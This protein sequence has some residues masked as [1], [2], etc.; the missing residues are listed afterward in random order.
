MV[1]GGGLWCST[2]IPAPKVQ[3]RFHARTVGKRPA[4]GVTD[5]HPRA[6]A[7]S[8]DGSVL[9]CDIQQLCSRCDGSSA[10]CTECEKRQEREEARKVLEHRRWLA[11]PE[12]QAHQRAE[13][14]RER[15]DSFI[16]SLPMILP[17]AFII[18]IFRGWHSLYRLIGS[19]VSA[20][21]ES[22]FLTKF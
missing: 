1:Q 4:A 5:T 10:I 3:V 15:M 21:W 6:T 22:W 14:R 8:A 20:V 11:S 13:K 18:Y 16:N 19:M 9:S 2:G 7:I 12:G 17:I